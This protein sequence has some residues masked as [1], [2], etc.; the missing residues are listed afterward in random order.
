VTDVPVEQPDAETPPSLPVADE[1]P[2]GTTPAAAER[3]EVT[4]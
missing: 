2:K 3:S 4:P 1:I